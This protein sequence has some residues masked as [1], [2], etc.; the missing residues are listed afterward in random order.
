MDDRKL[1]T[2]LSA[3]RAGSFSKAAS[4]LNCTQSA[5]TQ[6][7]NSLENELNC[8]LLIRSHNGVRLTETGKELLPFIIDADASLKRL[9]NYAERLVDGKEIPIRI[10]AFSSVSNTWLPEILYQYQSKHPNIA[11]DI[12]IGTDTLSNWLLSGEVDL[13]LGDKERC[14]TF[15]WHPL[16]DDPYYAVL[17][18][19][20][21]NDG[22]QSITQE[23]FA[24]FPLIMAPLNVLDKH[25][26]TISNRTIDV[27]CDD[28]STLLHMVSKGFGATAMPRMSLWNI[29]ENVRILHLSPV[30][31]RVIGVALPNSPRKAA[32]NFSNFLREHF[33][34][35]EKR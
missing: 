28:D 9:A 34:Y 24:S 15:S 1:E 30:P 4:Q 22:Q 2:I 20:Y 23:E 18:A 10:G 6:T 7:I 16:M 11:F 32:V 8:T 17:P 3:I 27:S 19:S 25:L 21:I 29:P 5:V 26:D 14:K 33:P 31:K 12:R 35:T 13:A